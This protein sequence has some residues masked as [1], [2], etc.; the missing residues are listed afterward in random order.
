MFNLLLFRGDSYAVAQRFWDFSSIIIAPLRIT[1][2]LVFLYQCVNVILWILDF[3]RSSGFLDG[4][5]YLE[6]SYSLLPVC[7]TTLLH[8][9]KFQ[10]VCFASR[11]FRRFL[12]VFQITRASWKAKDKRM[13]IVNELLQNIRFL[14]FYGWGGSGY[15]LT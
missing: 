6:S 9:T 8:G 4:V 1:I 3:K 10:S 13:D 14:K 11:S 12:L 15:L 5:L 7:L 2:A